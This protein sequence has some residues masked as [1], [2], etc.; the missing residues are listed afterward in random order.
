MH[1]TDKRAIDQS[2]DSAVKNCEF[3]KALE[4]RLSQARRA[5]AGIP[6]F[7]GRGDPDDP[8]PLPQIGPNLDLTAAS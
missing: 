6:W 1:V 5:I 4:E 7:G 8:D 2:L 3:A